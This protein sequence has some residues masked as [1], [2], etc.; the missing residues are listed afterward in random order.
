MT[1]RL[2]RPLRLQR[3]GFASAVD[4]RYAARLATSRGQRAEPGLNRKVVEILAVEP[5]VGV[6]IAPRRNVQRTGAAPSGCRPDGRKAGLAG[7]SITRIAD[8]SA[9][10][11]E[12]LRDQR[13]ERPAEGRCFR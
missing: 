9:E 1:P 7:S 12:P 10:R 13:V 6:G 3:D 8:S 11:F 4:R 5:V 2:S